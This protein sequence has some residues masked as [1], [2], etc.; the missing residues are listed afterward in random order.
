MD[1][2]VAIVSHVNIAATIGGDRQQ[3][4]KAGI[5]GECADY[6]RRVDFADHNVTSVGN[7][8][9]PKW[10]SRNTVGHIE[11]CLKSGPTIAAVPAGAI[12]R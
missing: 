9:V 3:V 4:A 1:Y 11:L 2:A 6:P 7:E 8:E 12:S 10:I 5:A